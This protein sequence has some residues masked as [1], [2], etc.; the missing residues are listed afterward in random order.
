M[1]INLFKNISREIS[2]FNVDGFIKEIIGRLKKMEE[3][4]VI[5][6]FEENVV[7]CENRN[8]G[9]IKEIRKEELAEGLK[10]GNII[11][12]ENGKYILDE[13]K[14]EEIEKRIKDK[15]NDLWN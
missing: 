3:E 6:R 8:T 13:E 10:E 7:I 5:D 4:L 9:E 1:E 11:K 14:Q 15:M 2:K 12:F